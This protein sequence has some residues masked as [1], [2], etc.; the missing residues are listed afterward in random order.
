MRSSM[1]IMMHFSNSYNNKP[2]FSTFHTA[3]RHLHHRHSYNQLKL[4]PHAYTSNKARKYLSLRLR[5]ITVHSNQRK[6]VPA[7]HAIP[8][9]IDSECRLRKLWWNFLCRQ[10]HLPCFVWMSIEAQVL[11][12][13]KQIHE[14]HWTQ[15]NKIT[16]KPYPTRW[17]RLYG[18]HNMNLLG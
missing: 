7:V 5:R 17:V 1:M 6:P 15:W 13:L 4:S 14:K 8:S 12:I 9:K 16:T 18:S 10:S 11:L 2:H 3:V